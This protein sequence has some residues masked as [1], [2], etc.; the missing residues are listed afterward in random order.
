VALLVAGGL[1]HWDFLAIFAV[2]MAVAA[3]MAWRDSMARVRRG[4][5]L[6]A[7]EVGVLL[8]TGAGTGA[9]MGALILG[10]LRAPLSTVEI[11]Q[12]R[13]LYL[14]KFRTDVTRLAV[15]EVVG[16]IAPWAFPLGR[17]ADARVGAASQTRFA[18][19]WLRGWTYV[20]A[21]G[22]VLGALTLR[23]PPA[24]FLALLVALPG[25]VGVGWVLWWIWRTVTG[26][27][28]RGVAAVVVVIVL[29]LLAVPGLLRWYRYP[30]LLDPV[31]V[32]QARTAARYVGS[33]LPAGRPVVFL[34]DY[35]GKPGS[36]A[37]V[38]K[39]RTILLALPPAHQ[40]DARLYIGALA[41]LLAG[42]RT[43][44]PDARTGRITQTY[45]TDVAPVLGE[46]P[47]VVA[48][49]ELAGAGFDQV[50]AAGGRQ[51]APDVAVLRGPAPARTIPAASPVDAV[52]S[53]F[54]GLGWG[55]ALLLLLAAAGGGWTL[56]ALRPGAE[57][58]AV[59]SLA[60][61]VGAGT[62]ILGGLLATELGVRLGRAGSVATVVVVGVSGYAVAIARRHRRA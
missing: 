59:V 19:R 43:P 11:G 24:R 27:A 45:W 23:V 3:A 20:M 9:I 56:A 6:L 42:R 54:A 18:V 60:P 62:L 57:P 1:A 29:G 58:E 25:A 41:D 10:L 40:T 28:R 34:V 5:P 14:R 12:D 21:A 35:L 39:E 8:A 26:G 7:T 33:A 30:E 17:G 2:V 52:P 48:I 22:I 51:V 49:R 47:P 15:P 31:G 50:L 46:R 32:Q 61:V 4:E 55:A 13:I 36:Y 44:P 37:T 53:W 16:L 38:V